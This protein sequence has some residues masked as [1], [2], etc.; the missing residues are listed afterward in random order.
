MTIICCQDNSI[1]WASSTTARETG[2]FKDISSKKRFNIP[3]NTT[4]KQPSVPWSFFD[5]FDPLQNGQAT[6]TQNTSKKINSEQTWTYKLEAASDAWLDIAAP[7]GG[8]FPQLPR[9]LDGVVQ[10]EPQPALVAEAGGACHLLEQVWRRKRTPELK[11]RYQDAANSAEV[12]IIS[13]ARKCGQQPW[14]IWTQ[15]R[16]QFGCFSSHKHCFFSVKYAF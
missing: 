14:R 9:D 1:I 4:I 3:M 7:E 12:C 15:M 5:I 6:S 11:H 16:L 13:K 8:H 10:Q 2:Y